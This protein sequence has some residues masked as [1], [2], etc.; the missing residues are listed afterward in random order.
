MTSTIPIWSVTRIEWG[1]LMLL[2]WSDH[3]RLMKRGCPKKNETVFITFI[4]QDTTIIWNCLTQHC[5]TSTRE[6][7]TVVRD[8]DIPRHT[9]P[10]PF[11]V[12]EYGDI[13][14]C[15]VSGEHHE[16]QAD[17]S[18]FPNDILWSDTS[19]TAHGDGIYYDM[20]IEN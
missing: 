9:S 13:L 19:E 5:Y 15:V 8:I 7:T 17:T 2:L 14:D 20:Y 4:D 12:A 6:N 3:F 18:D 10:N 1:T 16:S 11:H